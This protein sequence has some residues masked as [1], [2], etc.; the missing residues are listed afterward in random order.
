MSIVPMVAL[1]SSAN[2]CAIR[3]VALAL[4]LGDGFELGALER[5]AQPGQ[6]QH[7]GQQQ[8][9]PQQH[10]A[11]EIGAHVGG[12]AKGCEEGLGHRP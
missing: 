9:Q 10:A 4:A 1:T 12:S 7:H 6:R 5:G 11:A 3:D 8:R 2:A